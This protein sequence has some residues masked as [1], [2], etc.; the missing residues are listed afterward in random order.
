[1]ITRPL[2]LI[3]RTS[4]LPRRLTVGLLSL[5]CAALLMGA[6]A[7]EVVAEIRYSVTTIGPSNATPEGLN[8]L[9]Q[10]V[11]QT[12]N[13][14]PFIW[15]TAA[16]LEILQENGFSRSGGAATDIN[17]GGTV[18]GVLVDPVDPG[19]GTYAYKWDNSTTGIVRLGTATGGQ[20]LGGANAINNAGRIVGFY[21]ESSGN[22]DDDRV[23]QEYSPFQRPLAAFSGSIIEYGEAVDASETATG[24]AYHTLMN[25]NQVLEPDGTE[26]FFTHGY[27]WNGNGTPWDLNSPNK[28]QINPGPNIPSWDNLETIA[29]ALNDPGQVVGY[30]YIFPENSLLSMAF[31]RDPNGAYT[32]L[33]AFGVW[34]RATDINN[35]GLAVGVYRPSADE[36]AFLWSSSEGL[37][38]LNDLIDPTLGIS[39]TRATGINNIGQIIAYSTGAGGAR[40]A[41]FLTPVPEP[42]SL[43]LLTLAGLIPLGMRR[44]RN[45]K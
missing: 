2:S 34:S 23:P 45:C 38:N 29:T 5:V 32:A 18:V 24:G 13:G 26:F 25:S 43:V 12:D 39:L 7:D 30:G 17:D 33:G 37:L 9:G 16:G 4:F 8:N 21:Y 10:V 1:M 14:Q 20:L 41:Y 6:I 35:A 19:V 27:L 15:S 11:G 22:R 36:L 28:T 42:S 40:T 44:R 3:K 31:V